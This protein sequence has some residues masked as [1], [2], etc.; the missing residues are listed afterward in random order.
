MEDGDSLPSF[1]T[2]TRTDEGSLVLLM[3]LTQKETM[4]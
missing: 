3:I 1:I 2:D 4:V